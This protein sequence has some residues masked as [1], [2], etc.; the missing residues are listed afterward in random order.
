MCIHVKLFQNFVLKICR[1]ALYEANCF[2]AYER[3][4]VLVIQFRSDYLGKWSSKNHSCGKLFH[5][6]TY[7]R[8]ELFF[9]SHRHEVRVE[10]MRS[11]TF[12]RRPSVHL[13]L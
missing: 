4:V 6:L 10:Q 5:N 12:R 1:Y 3:L 13:F 11:L 7:L 8:C 9:S 2:I